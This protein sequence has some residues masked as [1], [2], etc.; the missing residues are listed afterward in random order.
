MRN[1]FAKCETA[2]RIP[3]TIAE[4]QADLLDPIIY[5]PFPAKFRVFL[6][7]NPSGLLAGSR[8]AAS[9]V[10]Q[11]KVL[12]QPAVQGGLGHWA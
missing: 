12:C 2:R 6:S 9:F 4:K 11:R 3:Q 1:V 7:A 5:D 8:A 10:N